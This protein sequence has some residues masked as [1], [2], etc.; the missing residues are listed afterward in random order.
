LFDNYS[1]FIEELERKLVRITVFIN[2]ASDTGVYYHFA[3]NNARLMR[4]VKRS[5][6]DGDSEFCR[7]R[8][9]VLLGMNGITKFEFCSARNV[10]FSS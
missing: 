8:Y 10:E 4:A 1:G 2:N 9:R 7:L 6:F 5:A 3:T